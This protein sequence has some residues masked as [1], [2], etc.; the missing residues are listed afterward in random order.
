MFLLESKLHSAYDLRVSRYRLPCQSRRQGWLR[1][2][3][4]YAFRRWDILHNLP[5]AGP[6]IRG[7]RR[8][9]VRVRQLRLRLDEHDRFLQL[10]QRPPLSVRPEGHRRGHQRR[11]AHR[12]RRPDGH[13][14]HLLRRHGMGGEGAKSPNS[15]H[16]RC[17]RRLRRRNIPR[18]SRRQTKSPRIHRIQ[19]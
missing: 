11:Q 7:V 3:K 4:N 2:V 18:T 14:P 13:D 12:V 1:A 17:N 6:G 19:K 8:N 10:P 5:L 9:R 15:N 16:H